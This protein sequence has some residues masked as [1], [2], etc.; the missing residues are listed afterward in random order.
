MSPFSISFQQSYA[1]HYNFYDGIESWLEES[2]MSTFPMNHNAT[3]LNMLGGG[4]PE[5]I[6]PILDSS[7]LHF[8]QLT[9]EKHVVGGLELLIGYTGIILS[10]SLLSASIA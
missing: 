3:K 1:N 5:S 8:L 9:F 10:L 2:Y 7:P 4:S 6:I